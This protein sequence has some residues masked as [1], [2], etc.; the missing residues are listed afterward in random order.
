M[1]CDK[2]LQIWS[3]MDPAPGFWKG[4]A[5]GAGVTALAA[6]LAIFAVLPPSASTLV[7]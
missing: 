5:G 1:S 3:S 7:S 2:N 6:A 4:A